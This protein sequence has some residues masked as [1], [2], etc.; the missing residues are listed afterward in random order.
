MVLGILG[1]AGLLT[2]AERVSRDAR[3]LRQRPTVLADAQLRILHR[4]GECEK[5]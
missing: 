5:P 1:A 3:R 2:L 4:L